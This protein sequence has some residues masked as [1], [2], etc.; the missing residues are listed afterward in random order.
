M[1]EEQH[2]RGDCGHCGYVAHSLAAMEKHILLHASG[3]T[4][5]QRQD[6][7]SEAGES[8]GEC[9][10]LLPD[11]D[12]EVDHDWKQMDLGEDSEPAFMER[13][14]YDGTSEDHHMGSCDMDGEHY[15]ELYEY[16]DKD[17][18]QSQLFF[19]PETLP[20][21]DE[22][23]S[24][25]SLAQTE[26]FQF[27][28][29]PSK[30]VVTPTGTTKKELY[31]CAHCDFQSS[32][33]C[34]VQEH[35]MVVHKSEPEAGQNEDPS[36][37]TIPW[38]LE[39]DE[40]YD[41]PENS[42]SHSNSDRISGDQTTKSVD[43]PE[44]WEGPTRFV[45]IDDSEF[46]TE[47]RFQCAFQGCPEV[48]SERRDFVSHATAAHSAQGCK[49]FYCAYCPFAATDCGSVRLHTSYMHHENRGAVFINLSKHQRH[50]TFSEELS[51]ETGLVNYKCLYCSFE[52]NKV[53]DS[54]MHNFK[55]HRTIWMELLESK[56]PGFTRLTSG[57]GIL[58]SLPR[59]LDPCEQ[60]IRKS[61]ANKAGAGNEDCLSTKDDGS[62]I[63]QENATN[64]GQQKQPSSSLIEA[65]SSNSCRR[66]SRRR[67]LL[68]TSQGASPV[69]RKVLH[70]QRIDGEISLSEN[71]PRRQLG[72]AGENDSGDTTPADDVYNSGSIL[73]GPIASA[74]VG[75]PADTNP[76]IPSYDVT[77]PTIVVPGKSPQAKFSSPSSV[78]NPPQGSLPASPA[79]SSPRKYIISN[80]SRHN[81]SGVVLSNGKV[82]SLLPGHNIKFNSRHQ[83]VNYLTDL[84]K[85]NGNSGIRLRQPFMTTKDN[86]PKSQNSIITGNPSSVTSVPNKRGITVVVPTKAS[87]A[88]KKLRIET[89]AS[90][91]KNSGERAGAGPRPVL[92][93]PL[94]NPH[95]N[96]PQKIFPNPA[97]FSKFLSQA[98]T[99][100]SSSTG[101]GY[102][103][104]RDSMNRT[105][106]V[107]SSGSASLLKQSPGSQQCTVN[108]LQN[109][110]K[111]VV[112]QKPPSNDIKTNTQ[113]SAPGG[114]R[115]INIGN[116]HRGC[117]KHQL[118]M[119]K[120]PA[121]KGYKFWVIHELNKDRVNS[122]TKES[123]SNPSIENKTTNGSQT[124]QSSGENF[125][126][127]SLH[128]KD[129]CVTDA[130][131]IQLN[132]SQSTVCTTT[133]SNHFQTRSV[134]SLVSS[135]SQTQSISN[136]ETVCTTQVANPPK[137]LSIFNPGGTCTC[138]SKPSQTQPESIQTPFCS[139]C[140][141]TTLLTQTV[142]CQQ[143]DNSVL[144]T[145]PPQHQ[146]VLNQGPVCSGLLTG[147]SQGPVCPTSLAG[148]SQTQLVYSQGPVSAPLLTAPPPQL[149][150]S[151]GP[152]CTPLVTNPTATGVVL[153]Q[154][155][156]GPVLVTNPPQTQQV[157]NQ[158]L[159]TAPS[160]T[161]LIYNQG[162]VG[163]PLT[164]N[165]SQ[166]QILHAQAPMI[167]QVV[168][169]PAQYSMGPLGTTLV[170]NASPAQLVYS[171][172][173]LCKASADDPSQPQPVFTQGAVFPVDKSV[174]KSG[175]DGILKAL[176]NSTGSQTVLQ[177]KG[178]DPAGFPGPQVRDS[179][180]H[181]QGLPGSGL[182]VR[183]SCLPDPS[184]GDPQIQDSAVS[185]T[186]LKE[187]IIIKPSNDEDQDG[188]QGRCDD[189]PSDCI[190]QSFMVV[191]GKLITVKKEK[192][193]CT[194]EQAVPPSCEY[195][196][197]EKN[198]STGFSWCEDSD[199][200]CGDTVE[201]NS[202]LYAGY[203]EEDWD[204][205]SPTPGGADGGDFCKFRPLQDHIEIHAEKKVKRKRK[206]NEGDL[207][208]GKK[209]VQQGP[210]RTSKRQR[211]ANFKCLCE[212]CR[213]MRESLLFKASNSSRPS[214][215]DDPKL[216]MKP[217][218]LLPDIGILLQDF[219]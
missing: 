39:L 45:P 212:E 77:Q 38:K 66:A 32:D 135:P 104:S 165:L 37:P 209:Q 163:T 213:V 127:Q 12:P 164:T 171:Q 176:L 115:V 126:L 21:K 211:K 186:C 133:A 132:S 10:E 181:Y 67:P 28:S 83:L 85:T 200:P 174:T 94:Q 36:D 18:M 82:L 110:G 106:L 76:S 138:V 197:G 41:N 78:P 139:K 119:I 49:V 61:V 112:V 20:E 140:G 92:I 210:V 214:Q 65:R 6:E 53:P 141:K 202:F 19:Q 121:T 5:E 108:P 80:G 219:N 90:A 2:Y 195:E 47:P 64:S 42:E 95:Q 117:K 89:L 79:S 8:D 160:Q 193:D 137:T 60:L 25:L 166:T 100:S 75:P 203:S 159:L 134:S 63:D 180:E 199:M 177:N 194:K 14:F 130:A 88:D 74:A 182:E 142:S 120:D 187:P 188:D 22:T 31:F 86:S 178:N 116:C 62:E 129:V 16:E 59:L 97:A 68:D 147:P 169:G 44:P 150:Y 7:T 196:Q 11:P 155:P 145:N 184:K 136:Q 144:V 162:S 72:T 87:G 113:V 146:V 1:P 98:S 17:A 26:K 183:A 9:D 43:T 96:F 179:L 69:P 84:K 198:G 13:E 48:F 56:H 161:Q 153:G 149:V 30:V 175:N 103:I 111:V 102:K 124:K 109:S 40:D 190:K 125:L 50:V 23:E 101:S 57:I 54:I 46:S 55:K 33:L 189:S 93:R 185:S 107:P 58:E 35:T 156:L 170:S 34:S 105:V 201:D 4:C 123:D 158:S 24:S 152:V 172:D 118:F 52:T 218:V 205:D 15:R 70:L 192:E 131:Q 122:Q 148:P 51:Q 157:F 215:Q 208:R 217:V 71:C 91:S 173:S 128:R 216:K 29:Q 207:E 143:S 206:S 151:Q 168:N 204:V 154:G 191:D 27:S 3:E 99:A 73:R 81:S 114:Q 167:P